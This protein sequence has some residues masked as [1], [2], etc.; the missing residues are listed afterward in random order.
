MISARFTLF[1]AVALSCANAQI[2]A[3]FG[4]TGELLNVH[5]ENLKTR[6]VDSHEWF[7]KEAMT[8]SSGWTECVK[9][10][11]KVIG[12]E[13]EVFS[14]VSKHPTHF[15]RHSK[16]ALSR[17]PEA[18]NRAQ[19]NDNRNYGDE[20]WH[21]EADPGHVDGCKCMCSPDTNCN[22]VK[23]SDRFVKVCDGQTPEVQYVASKH[24]KAIMASID[25]GVHQVAGTNG[26][27]HACKTG[28]YSEHGIGACHPHTKC[29]SIQYLTGQSSSTAG[30]CIDHTICDTVS[31]VELTAGDTFTD[32]TCDCKTLAF[33]N[34]DN[35]GSCQHT[36]DISGIT[37]VTTGTEWDFT[38]SSGPEGEGQEIIIEEG[39][40]LTINIGLGID[41]VIEPCPGL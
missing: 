21:C 15:L 29:S 1:A 25:A 13:T 7:H 24:Q 40:E 2:S 11:C 9:T 35:A 30:V 12:Q 20:H 27:G 38:V 41:F 5:K 33:L 28:T 3:K 32:N 8:A 37:T 39:A 26:V 14:H 22:S 34:Y 23:H 36:C 17:T 6:L 10:F 16:S 4:A 31:T 19:L 18:R